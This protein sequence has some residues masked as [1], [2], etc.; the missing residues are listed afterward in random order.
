MTFPEIL[1]F[2]RFFRF[3]RP[4]GNPESLDSVSTANPW[5]CWFSSYDHIHIS[6]FATHFHVSI[7]FH[8]IRPVNMSTFVYVFPCETSPEHFIRP[9]DPVTPCSF[10]LIRKNVGCVCEKWKN[11]YKVLK[12]HVLKLTSMLLMGYFLSLLCVST[13]IVPLSCC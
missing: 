8:I 11:M 5:I 12:V 7:G 3:S 10:D 6:M 13:P 4:C 9:R 2:F 1:F